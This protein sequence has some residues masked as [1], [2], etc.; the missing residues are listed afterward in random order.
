MSLEH[1]K[2]ISKDVIE[3]LNKDGKND[4]KFYEITEV[5]LES[6]L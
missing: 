5:E 6:I 3:A 4:S 2:K 1:S